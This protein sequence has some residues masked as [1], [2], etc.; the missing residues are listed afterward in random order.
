[1][2]S[3]WL[4]AQAGP[5]PSPRCTMFQLRCLNSTS[6]T[7]HAQILPSS[8]GAWSSLS[9]SWKNTASPSR[10][11]NSH[12]PPCT[13][14][15]W[16]RWHQLRKAWSM[17]TISCL[18]LKLPQR[19]S[20]SPIASRY[21]RFWPLRCKTSPPTVWTKSV[22]TEE[23]AVKC[24]NKKCAE[25]DYH[26]HGEKSAFRFAPCKLCWPL[27]SGPAWHLNSCQ[28]RAKITSLDIL[29]FSQKL[30]VT[31]ADLPC[32]SSMPYESLYHLN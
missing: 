18:R 31:M 21:V 15:S 23:W 28:Q 3:L 22:K 17:L 2:S 14:K 26:L 32:A 6:S 25:S 5:R 13:S 16:V 19:T 1:M 30:L 11:N 9:A 24:T 10:P 7:L 4:V 27:C 8:Q 12:C 20:S 29:L